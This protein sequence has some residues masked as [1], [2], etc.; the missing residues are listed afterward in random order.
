MK[1]RPKV[2]D[3]VEFWRRG[4]QIGTVVAVAETGAHFL[5][6]LPFTSRMERKPWDSECKQL[7]VGIDAIIRILS[8]ACS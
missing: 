3:R 4:V 7:R 8:S 1:E 2:G 6:E 5:I